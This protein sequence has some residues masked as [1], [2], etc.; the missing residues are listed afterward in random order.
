MKSNYKNKGLSTIIV[1]VLLIGLT[2]VAVGIVASVVNNLIK[3]KMLNTEACFGNFGKVSIDPQYT[4]FIDKPIGTPDEFQFSIFIGDID[5]EKIIIGISSAGQTKSY[6]IPGKYADVRKYGA[7]GTYNEDLILPGRNAGTTYVV[8][9]FISK[10]D[11]IKIAP[12]INGQQC[13]VSDT[14]VEID[15]CL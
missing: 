11:S 2:I 8:N 9:S 3:G 7:G 6:T 4:C 13:D 5:V 15:R 14:L 1:T 12:V 10:P